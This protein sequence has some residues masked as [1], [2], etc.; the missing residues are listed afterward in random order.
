MPAPRA[1]GVSPPSA[2]KYLHQCACTLRGSVLSDHKGQRVETDAMQMHDAR[3]QQAVACQ[4]LEGP[5]AL[6]DTLHIRLK[7]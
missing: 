4:C 7:G 5:A 3:Q 6:R 1:A 2:F